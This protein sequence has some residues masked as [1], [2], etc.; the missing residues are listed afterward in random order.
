MA[1]ARSFLL[2]A[3][4]S[5]AS[6]QVARADDGYSEVAAGG[7]EF[8]KTDAITMDKEV[9]EI[10]PDRISVSYEFRNL[11]SADVTA[12]VAFPLPPV[13]CDAFDRGVYPSQFETTVDGAAI[14]TD[15]EVR[16]F[17]RPLDN[18]RGVQGVDPGQEV[19]AL[20][21]RH[22]LPP[23]CRLAVPGP[24]KFSKAT[25]TY[26]KAVSLGLAGPK[27]PGSDPYTIYYESHI[28]YYWQQTF[29]AHS[30]I[31]ITHAYRP[32]YGGG[33][34]LVPAAY[35]SYYD[36]FAVYREFFRQEKTLRGYKSDFSQSRA[37]GYRV[38][39]FILKSANS[40]A[41]P[42]KDFKLVL[43]NPPCFMVTSLPGPLRMEG[44]DIVIELKDFTP[45]SDLQV[46]YVGDKFPRVTAQGAMD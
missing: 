18:G 13:Q 11:T 40:W 1:Y 43:K 45:A 21:T 37:F 14:K 9:L 26:L 28:K 46:F 22:G 15:V 27:D 23:D 35:S 41:G 42:I 25:P 31:R 24:P 44:D 36:N 6:I 16:A 4:F 19:T 10:T 29:P 20:L 34:M 2:A 12:T 39:D 32:A 33:I 30:V 8:T 3:I 17:A 5:V 38:I 7:L